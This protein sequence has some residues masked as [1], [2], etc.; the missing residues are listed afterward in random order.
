MTVVGQVLDPA[1]KPVVGAVVDIIGRDRKPRVAAEE[2]VAPYVALGHGATD[3]GGHFRLEAS[4]TSSD[5]FSE[6]HAL[7]AAP[8]Y[9]LGWVDLNSD[10]EQPAADIRLQP[11]QIIRGRLVDVNGQPATGVEV[12]VGRIHN[13]IKNGI[14]DGVNLGNDLPPEGLRAWPQPVTTDDHGS[15]QADGHRPE[16]LR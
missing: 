12:R 1:G 11:E 14:Y 4:R 10:A 2:G 9:G 15:L 16:S 5:G 6:V 7:A 13:P 8:G 3:D